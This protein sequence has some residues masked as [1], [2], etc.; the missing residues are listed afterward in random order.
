LTWMIV[1]MRMKRKRTI[2]EAEDQGVEK[3]RVLDFDDTIAQTTERVRVE[4][5]TGPKMISSQEFAVYDF[6]P[7]ESLDPMQAFEEFSKVDVKTAQPVP[8]VSGLLKTFIEA[9]GNRRILIL[10]ARGPEV[11]PYVM[12]FLEKKLGIKSP[13]SKVDFVGV[14]DK[15]PMKK[16]EVIQDY[17]DKN[18]SIRFV[19]FYDDS[20]KNVKA[21]ADYLKS[22]GIS[23][24]VRQV[25]KDDEGNFSLVR[26]QDEILPNPDILNIEKVQRESS[27][28]ILSENNL[29]SIIRQELVEQSRKEIRQARKKGKAELKA[30]HAVLKQKLKVSKVDKRVKKLLDKFA[31]MPFD[32]FMKKYNRLDGKRQKEIDTLLAAV[33]KGREAEAAVDSDAAVAVATDLMKAPDTSAIAGDLDKTEEELA[34]EQVG[35]G[36]MGKEIKLDTDKKYTY[37]ITSKDNSAT[38]KSGTLHYTVASGPKNV[39]KSFQLK[40]TTH[41][42]ATKVKELYPHLKD[43]F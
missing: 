32:K 25:V 39:G 20:G 42:L 26:H 2:R 23:S 31:D 36:A 14:Q 11:E 7:G 24:D 40:D 12:K 9:S 27:K 6:L 17:L 22:R 30:K 15:D 35:K 41:E 33:E 29:R 18:P 1:V 16:V 38:I 5:P 43:K 3:L 37:K 10:T 13:A 8:F 28:M 19:S 21:V 34:G 4:T